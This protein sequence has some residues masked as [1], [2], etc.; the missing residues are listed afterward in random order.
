M[1]IPEI[2]CIRAVT[3]FPQ[4]SVCGA[5]IVAGGQQEAGAPAETVL[6][7]GAGPPHGDP[8]LRG[9]AQVAAAAAVGR[10]HWKQGGSE[11]L[12]SLLDL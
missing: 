2:T 6:L 1:E 5:G 12:P 11:S 7:A 8:L 10:Q 4:A 9:A 3:C